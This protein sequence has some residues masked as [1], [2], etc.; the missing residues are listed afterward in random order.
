MAVPALVMLALLGGVTVY[1]A[2][3][4]TQCV[5]YLLPHFPFAAALAVFC[6]LTAVLA[7]GFVRS[8]LPLPQAAKNLLKVFSAYW[9]G[10]FVYLLL[11]LLLADAVVFAGW[12][13]KLVPHPMP[14]TVR[15][16]SILTALVLTAATCVYGFW[17]ASHI[18]T[19]TYEV[20]LP[21]LEGEMTIALASDLH[22]GAVGSEERLERVVQTLNGMEADIICLAGDLFDNDFT[23]V[24]D[25]ERAAQQLKSLAA[26][27]GVYACLGNHDAGSTFDDMAAFLESCGVQLLCESHAVA[28]GRLVLAGRADR[29]PIG[30]SRMRRG[31]V[32]DVLKGAPDLPVVVMDHNPDGAEEYGDAVQLVLSG[33]THRGQIFPGSLFTGRMYAVD[34]GYGRLEN[35]PQ[36]IVTSGA[37]T[38]GMPMRVGTDC[39]AV[40]IKLKPE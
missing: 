23:A 3:R 39:E 20:S 6:V 34:Y 26:E 19:K 38:W 1:F 33:H 40:L 37:G 27:Y 21:G 9:M 10:A 5:Q 32:S 12:L 28:D 22:L 14:E 13:V 30:G 4:V 15:F 36:I 35:G 31:E 2:R 17:H 25:P 18:H 7:V 8:V 16:A 24:R 29:S 11:Y